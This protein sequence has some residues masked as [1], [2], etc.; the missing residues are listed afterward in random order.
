[1]TP[2]SLTTTEDIDGGVKLN[3]SWGGL[4]SVARLDLLQ[5]WIAVLQQ[6]YQLTH[7]DTY[8]KGYD[9]QSNCVEAITGW[10]NHGKGP[11]DYTPNIVKLARPNAE[12]PDA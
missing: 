11:E 8:G 7:H 5:D 1:M 2:I 4:H 9:W 10:E 12:K 6:L 3:A